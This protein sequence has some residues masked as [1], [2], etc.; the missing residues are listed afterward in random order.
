LPRTHEPAT[1]I[2]NSPPESLDRPL[3]PTY[4]RVVVVEAV[5]ILLLW[6]L[7]RMFS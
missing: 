5:I 6:F 7:G 2:P 4:V 3:S 1:L